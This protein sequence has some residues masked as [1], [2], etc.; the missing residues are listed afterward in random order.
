[1]SLVKRISYL[2]EDRHCST[3]FRPS[4]W[5]LQDSPFDKLTALSRIEGRTTSDESHG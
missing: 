1:M 5:T 2:A 4:G 3:G